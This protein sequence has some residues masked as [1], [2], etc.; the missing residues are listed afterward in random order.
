MKRRIL[1]I[2]DEAFLARIV[3][4]TLE[5]R[6]F[7]V[8]HRKDG[9]RIIE[10]IKA[11]NPDV[12]VLDVMLP[13]IDGFSLG[14]SIRNV[15]P[16]LPILY[17]TAKTQTSDVLD[18]FSAGGTDYL[19]K[20]F[21]MEEL[22]V[23][24]ENQVRLSA[25]DAA[26]T[27]LPDELALGLYRFFP[28]KYELRTEARIVRLSHREAQVLGVLCRHKNVLLDRSKLLHQVWGDDSFFN[29]RTLDVYIRKLRE[30]LS[31][32]ERL[33]IVTLKGKGYQFVVPEKG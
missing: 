1:Y 20:P 24:I 23:R 30:Y 28:A 26:A 5:R 7:E 10:H 17:V 27:I 8:L 9:T 2:E 21:S 6:G 13:H 16:R 14:S 25:A 29:S 3:R 22:V 12:C 4:E 15:Y 18:G 19:K 31:G 33:Q 32:D 11:F